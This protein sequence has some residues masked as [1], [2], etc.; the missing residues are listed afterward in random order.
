MGRCRLQTFLSPTRHGGLSAAVSSI[1]RTAGTRLPRG[2]PN[3]TSH[4]LGGSGSIFAGAIESIAVV[5]VFMRVP[6]VRTG[7]DS[8]DQETGP[9]LPSSALP[10]FRMADWLPVEDRGISWGRPTHP[11]RVGTSRRPTDAGLRYDTPRPPRPCCRL[12]PS[13]LSRYS[14]RGRLEIQSSMSDSS[15]PTARGPRE[16]G[17]G[18]RSALIRRHIV[19]FDRPTRSIT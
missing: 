17:F 16:M 6:G 10:Y 12:I 3:S 5:H 11:T 8:T 9:F 15:Q 4:R 1:L 2:H 18:N 7:Y 13:S 14:A 19:D